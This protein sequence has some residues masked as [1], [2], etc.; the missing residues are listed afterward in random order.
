MTALTLNFAGGSEA[1]FN[2]KRTHSVNLPNSS[3]QQWTVE[4]LLDWIRNNM[5]Q[6]CDR[7]DML[8]VDGRSL[9]FF[10]FK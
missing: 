6:N 5:L 3:E 2:G 1:I 9:G 10:Y 8:I 4:K 7:T